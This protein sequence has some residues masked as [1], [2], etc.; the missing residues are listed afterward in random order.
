MLNHDPRGPLSASDNYVGM[1]DEEEILR[2][3][4]QTHSFGEVLVDLDDFD[5]DI[6]NGN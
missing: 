1:S 2:A 3:A 5:R 6:L 4:S